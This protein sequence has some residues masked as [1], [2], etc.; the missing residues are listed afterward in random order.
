MPETFL[1]AISSKIFCIKVD[2][3]HPGLPVMKIFILLSAPK[4]YMPKAVLTAIFFDYFK[5]LKLPAEQS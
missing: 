5:H 2:L 1:S 4:Q 3:P